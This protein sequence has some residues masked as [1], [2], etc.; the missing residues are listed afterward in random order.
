MSWFTVESPGM[1]PDCDGVKKLVSQKKLNIVIIILCLVLTNECNNRV[2]KF[3]KFGPVMNTI[4]WFNLFVRSLSLS[5]QPFY[6]TSHSWW[7]KSVDQDILERYTSLR[8]IDNNVCYVRRITI[9]I[10]ILNRF[11]ID[12]RKLLP[13]QVKVSIMIPSDTSFGAFC[14]RLAEFKNAKYRTTISYILL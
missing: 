4:G 10:Y 7:F 12:R 14:M 5:N 6:I 8:G 2:S 13:H 11:P 9:N 1:K 3:S